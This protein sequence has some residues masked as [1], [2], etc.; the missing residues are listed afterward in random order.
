MSLV[1]A[2]DFSPDPDEEVDLATRELGQPDAVFRAGGR[3][4]RVKTVVGFGFV[5][6]GLVANY[7]WWVHGPAQF[8]HLE[9]HLLFWPPII[10]AALLWFL[11]RNRGLR[12]VVFPTGVLRL[13]QEEV[14]SFPWA[15]ITVVRQRT[16]A[17]EPQLRWDADGRLTACWLPVS[18]PWVQVWDAWFEIERAD[19]T[20]TRFTPG[21]A[22]YPDLSER[23]QV[24]TFQALWPKVQTDLARGV[25][26]AFG[27][28]L[29]SRDGLTQSGRLLKW[30][31]IKAI[32]IVHKIIT[33]KRKDSWRTWWVKGT[34]EI[35]NLHVLLGV[36]AILGPKKI[37][38]EGDEAE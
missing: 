21:V 24:G 6:Y 9:F 13:K 35:P 15:S 10:G 16:D 31:D 2:D 28:L 8:G 22:N 12:V 17:A 36:L 5:I 18:I 37:E 25:P 26:I 7:F 3:W 4:A 1:D 14:E 33:V 11:Y 34:S 32:T 20:K 23:V 19:G 30:D 27:D 29:V 38:V